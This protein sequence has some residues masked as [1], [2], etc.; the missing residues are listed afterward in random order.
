VWLD[1]VFQPA[2]F[3]GVAGRA[4]RPGEVTGPDLFLVDVVEDLP[5]PPQRGV[6]VATPAQP[7][8]QV[9]RYVEERLL[10]VDDVVILAAPIVAITAGVARRFVDV[11]IEEVRDML[12][13]V[14]LK[15]VLVDGSYARGRVPAD[16]VGDDVVVAGG[17]VRR[18]RCELLDG[19]VRPPTALQRPAAGGRILAVGQEDG[20]DGGLVRLGVEYP[21]LVVELFEPRYPVGQRR[22]L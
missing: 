13:V 18:E 19:R 3:G 1:G 7:A 15:R 5:V 6:V 10:D 16:D 12:D 4:V 17:V 9:D 21:R 20:I 11:C 2:L 22:P 8:G 14:V